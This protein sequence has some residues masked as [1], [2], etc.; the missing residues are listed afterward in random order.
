MTLPQFMLRT[1]TPNAG[2]WAANEEFHA[3]KARTGK[4]LAVEEFRFVENGTDE[5]GKE[6]LYTELDDV[7]TLVAAFAALT[8][9]GGGTLVFEDNRQYDLNDYAAAMTLISNTVIEGNGATLDVDQATIDAFLLSAVGEVGPDITPRIDVI[10]GAEVIELPAGSAQVGEYWEIVSNRKYNGME[11]LQTPNIG[12][13]NRVIKVQNSEDNPEWDLVSLDS[14]TFGD[15]TIGQRFAPH[16]VQHYA[17]ASGI[18]TALPG[19]HDEILN[20]GHTISLLVGDY[21]YIGQRSPFDAIY[22][23]F[24]TYAAA[25]VVLGLEYLRRDNTWQTATITTDGTTGFTNAGIIDHNARG[26]MRVDAAS[27]WVLGW[28][29]SPATGA[30]GGTVDDGISDVFSVDTSAGTSDLYWM[31]LRTNTAIPSIQINEIEC[32]ICSGYMLSDNVVA[33]K[34]TPV[35]NITIRNLRILGKHTATPLRFYRTHNLLLDN[36]HVFG[37]G[38]YAVALGDVEN[39]KIRDGHYESDREHDAQ[40]QNGTNYGIGI[41]GSSRHITIE[42]GAYHRFRHPIV[43]VAAESQPGVARFIKIVNCQF[44]NTRGWGINGHGTLEYVTVANCDFTNVTSNLLDIDTNY[45]RAIQSTGSFWKIIGNNISGFRYGVTLS[46]G[47]SLIVADNHFDGALVDVS[48]GGF[49]M[50][51][52]RVHDNTCRNSSEAIEFNGQIDDITIHHNS[53]LHFTAS[54]IAFTNRCIPVRNVLIDGNTFHDNEGGV[55]TNPVTSEAGSLIVGM[56]IINNHFQK[57]FTATLFSFSGTVE[58]GSAHGNTYKATH[59]TTESAASP[60]ETTIARVPP[61]PSFGI[62]IADGA[63]YEQVIAMPMA[64]CRDPYYISDQ[65]LAFPPPTLDFEGCTYAC[66]VLANGEATLRIFNDTGASKTISGAIPNG[67]RWLFRL[68]RTHG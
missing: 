67:G 27:D 66:F 37:S 19:T 31:R 13:V 64:V 48:M 62:T 61:E 12:Q 47:S 8:A 18:L 30:N 39:V 6:R 21:L 65:V 11:D 41:G 36:V 9:Q 68:I 17:A 22:F 46:W 63:V 24:Q 33:R 7:P 56:K 50:S 20:L 58:E 54:G 42:G 23:R 49:N 26:V 40:L 52:M 43:G 29:P 28:L 3:L 53:F 1:N 51:D 16:S 2:R 15:V 38:A 25:P 14:Q 44:F 59:Y 5:T 57:M 45:R 34:R 55:S 10:Y 60:W 4:A 35:E 32:I